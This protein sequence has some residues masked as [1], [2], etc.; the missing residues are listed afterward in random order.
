MAFKAG[1]FSG[2][3]SCE[4]SKGE[5]RVLVCSGETPKNMVNRKMDGEKEESI[6]SSITQKES[7]T[8]CS[9]D[10]EKKFQGMP[11]EWSRNRSKRGKS[12]HPRQMIP[13][14]KKHTRGR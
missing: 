14:L 7:F 5:T 10:G 2:L 9:Q 1:G 11:S 13:E 8:C 4:K 6:L 12:R 3:S